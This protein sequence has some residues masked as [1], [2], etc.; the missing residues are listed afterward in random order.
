MDMW[1]C[2][3]SPASVF[4]QII[5]QFVGQ[6]QPRSYFQNPANL[7][8]VL[9][10]APSE[11]VGF[12]FALHSW[13]HGQPAD[14]DSPDAAILRAKSFLSACTG[15]THIVPATQV[16]VSVAVVTDVCN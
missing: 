7:A 15:Y 8:S 13:L 3:V 1:G 10:S 11:Q 16:L 6:D 9:R 5:W 4:G 12:L 14:C 2:P